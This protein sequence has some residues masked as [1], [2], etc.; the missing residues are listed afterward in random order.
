[1]KIKQHFSGIDGLRAISVMLVLLAHWEPSSFFASL[2]EWGRGGLIIFFVISGFLI[3]GILLDQ[4]QKS[5]GE[6]WSRLLGNFY[7]RRAFRIFPLYYL[8]LAF[9]V[10]MDL[11]TAVTQDVGWHIVFLNNFSA[12]FIRGDIGPYGP[13]FPWWSLAVEEQFYLLWAPVVL[14]APRRWVIPIIISAGISALSFR[15]IGWL[16]GVPV[17]KLFVL[18]LGNF[19]ALAAGCGIAILIRSKHAELASTAAWMKAVCALSFFGLAFLSYEHQELGIAAFRPS[20][21]NAVVS[22]ACWYGIA[23]PLIFFL[24]INRAK[25]IGMFLENPVFVF[26]GQRS[27][28]IY[29]LHQVVA[30]T[31]YLRVGPRLERF[32]GIK[33]Q[34]YGPT[35]FILYFAITLALATISYKYFETPLLRYRDRKFGPKSAVV[36]EATT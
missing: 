16:N 26:I 1:M 12:I 35:E 6:K 10:W 29:I 33:L 20:V 23:A 17:G 11:T 14:I 18:T 7:L 30:H 32:T 13:T 19:D 36:R 9:V 34:L 25:L 3:T 8:V 15:Y 21:L 5:E 4:R 28:G 22:D 31:M 27:Y 24:A 2:M